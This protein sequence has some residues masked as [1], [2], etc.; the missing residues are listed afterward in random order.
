M[1]HPLRPLGLVILAF[2]IAAC[3]PGGRPGSSAAGQ[4]FYTP[5]EPPSSRYVIDARVDVAAAA[6]EGRETIALKNAGS[7]RPTGPLPSRI[8]RRS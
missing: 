8:R 6:V 5:A 4:P 2:A 3:G 7:F 1:N